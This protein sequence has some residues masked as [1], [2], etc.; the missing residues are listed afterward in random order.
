MLTN[1]IESKV[2]AIS[3]KSKEEL[4][5]FLL[6]ILKESNLKGEQDI[7]KFIQRHPLF[8]ESMLDEKELNEIRNILNKRNVDFS[9]YRPQGEEKYKLVFTFKDGEKVRE[10]HEE[11]ARKKLNLTRSSGIQGY[12]DNALEKLKEQ[13]KNVTERQVKLKEVSLDER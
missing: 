10:A 9:F 6:E 2:I 4:V 7:E 11:L 13:N 12:I 8:N 3:S 1:D 5:K